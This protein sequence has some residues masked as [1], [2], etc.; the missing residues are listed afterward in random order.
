MTSKKFPRISIITPSFNQ[1][2]FLEETIKSVL[3]QSYENIEYIVVDGKST[4]G[5]HEIIEKYQDQ[6]IWIRD[7]DK[8]QTDAINK[9][10]NV[11]TGT[12]LAYLNSDDLYLPDTLNLVIKAFAKNT[13]S[14]W[15]TGDCI[16]I[17]QQ[18]IEINKPI[19]FYKRLLSLFNN[20]NL[21]AITNYISQ[22]ST[23]MT[24]KLLDKL[25]P[26]DE[27][28]EYNM[29]FSY[30]LKSYE[31]Q[32]PVI[33]TAALSKFRVHKNSKGS[34]KLRLQ[35]A[36]GTEVLKKQHFCKTFIN[37]KEQHDK[38]IIKLYE[39]AFRK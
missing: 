35:F 15:L 7:R 22:P 2:Q 20:R 3:S 4:D 34:N 25:G 31:I 33:L 30:W 27:N 5:S 28:L 8:N 13:N 29:D 11:A 32:K 16:I 17:N 1:G 26:L 39:K 10:F 21:L 24:K 12:I 9:G 38:I 14:F 23:F 19:R 6:L 37:A 18:G 36:E